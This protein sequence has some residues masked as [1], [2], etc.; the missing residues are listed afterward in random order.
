MT[1]SQKWIRIS[2]A[3]WAALFFWYWII[4]KF[5]DWMHQ[6][7]S[8][9]T[10]TKTCAN[11]AFRLLP[12]RYYCRVK[13]VQY[14]NVGFSPQNMLHENL[15]NLD[16]K[17]HRWRSIVGNFLTSTFFSFTVV[18]ILFGPNECPSGRKTQLIATL[19]VKIIGR[20]VIINEFEAILMENI[21]A[22]KLSA[23]LR[24][25]YTA[26]CRLLFQQTATLSS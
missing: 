25:T 9:V 22:M 20:K 24:A 8:Q 17:V 18:M 2:I 5:K 16:S 12:L 13:T 7:V 10:M 11:A 23:L 19:S 6:K 14:E 3:S 4:A 15:R 26:N 21:G 1:P